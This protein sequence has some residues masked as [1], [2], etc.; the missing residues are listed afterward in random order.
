M[1][2]HEMFVWTPPIKH[3]KFQSNS[4]IYHVKLQVMS[5]G[6]RSNVS[7]LKGELPCQQKASCA[8]SH[9]DPDLLL[10]DKDNVINTTIPGNRSA[11]T[12]LS[13]ETYGIK[14]KTL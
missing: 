14:I 8:T 2:T 12:K 5:Q 6:D 1:L 7:L 10:K 13:Q 9:S 11:T 3:I 4:W